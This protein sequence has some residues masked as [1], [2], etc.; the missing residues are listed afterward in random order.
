MFTPTTLFLSVF[1]FFPAAFGDFISY[2]NDFVDPTYLLAKN[3]S[4]STVASQQTVMEW[5][6]ELA[7]QGPWSKQRHLGMDLTSLCRRH[8]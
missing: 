2:G 3:F 8:E 6:E 7:A 4:T 5:A 1:A